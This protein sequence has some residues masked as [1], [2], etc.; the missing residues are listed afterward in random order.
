MANSNEGGPLQESANE[1]YWLSSCASVR[2]RWLSKNSFNG[3]SEGMF[4][5][6]S[7]SCIAAR[8]GWLFGDDHSALYPAALIAAITVNRLGLASS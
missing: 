4:R 1:M 7:S 3:P 6:A 8:I 5:F 2:L